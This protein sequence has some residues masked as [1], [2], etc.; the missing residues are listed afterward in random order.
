M[1]SAESLSV[2]QSVIDHKFE[3]SNPAADGTVRKW[4]EKYSFGAC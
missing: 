1:A 4:R 3:G 2:E